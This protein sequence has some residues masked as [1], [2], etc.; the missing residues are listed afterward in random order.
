VAAPNE[1]LASSLSILKGLQDRGLS[2]FQLSAH[3]ELTRTHRERL[4]NAGFLKRVIQGWYQSNNPEDTEGDSTHWYANM[5]TFVAEY[6][7]SRFADQ[8]QVSPE[9]SLLKH[10]G[11]TSI[12]KQILLYS[13]L[14]TNQPQALPH[15][16]SM[17][18]YRTKPDMLVD[19]RTPNASGLMLVP[20]P[21]ALIR[22]SP[23]FFQTHELA[24]QIVTR[25]VDISTLTARLL[26]GGHSVVAGRIAGAL[27]AVGRDQDADQLLDTM[28][29]AAYVVVEDNPFERPLAHI[30]GRMNE[31]PYVQR[32]QAMWS[33]MR[34]IVIDRF[35]NIPR[36]PNRDSEALLHDI[37]A[38][39]VADAY[40]S[41]SIEGYRVSTDLITKVRN[42]DWSPLTNKEDRLTRDAM[43][44]KGYGETHARVRSLIGRVVAQAEDPST[45]LKRDFSQWYVTLFSPSVSAGILKA[46][47]LAG[48][49]NNNVFIRNALHV[50]LAPEAVRDCMPALF[51]LLQA[52]EHPGVRAVLGHFIFVFI[53]P[54]M[55]GN[56][57][58]SRFLMNYLLTTGGYL[59]TI[60][61]VQSRTAY[62]AALEQAST[63]RNIKPFADLIG[64]LIES[65]A[66]EPIERITQRPEAG[67]WTALPPASS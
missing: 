50:P 35:R 15:G 62:L 7:R 41:L 20:V 67:S 30:G 1:K 51:D 32:I 25:Q 31:S 55:D 16:C 54:Y 59:W 24:A 33:G 14:A 2:V 26:E 46:S 22:A 47:D 3:P 4:Q 10:S 60:V 11:H 5:E 27:R 29:A 42:G 13:P 39:Y 17:F 61:T 64:G 57:R 19:G 65:Q 9:L 18:L 40:H 58:L 37:E 49:R 6:A 45:T 23:S 34:D 21:E 36:V 53:H 38:R 12:E 63:Y 44:A 56:G 52:E 43:A 28:K 8:W 66:A 48:Y